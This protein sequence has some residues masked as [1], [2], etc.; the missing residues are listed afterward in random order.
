MLIAYTKGGE[1]S[2]LMT[3][4]ELSRCEVPHVKIADT[5][6]AGDSF[7]ATYIITGDVIMKLKVLIGCAILVLFLLFSE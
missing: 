6:G 3:L 1:G 2:W 5:V 4:N 7:T